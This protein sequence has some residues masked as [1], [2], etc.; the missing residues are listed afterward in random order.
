MVGRVA[1]VN[2]L[3]FDLHAYQRSVS[4]HVGEMSAVQKWKSQC[5]VC[6]HARVRYVSSFFAFLRAA[7]MTA[8][9]YMLNAKS[10]IALDAN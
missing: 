9:S 1:P 5:A 10:Q 3:E 2:A 6:R 4:P 8:R 7:V